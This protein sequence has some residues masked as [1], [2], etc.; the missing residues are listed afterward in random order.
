MST[1]GSVRVWD[2][3]TQATVA[4]IEGKIF[5]HTCNL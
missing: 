3:I 2:Y 4:V 1:E 5:M